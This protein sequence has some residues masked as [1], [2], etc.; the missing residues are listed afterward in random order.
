MK[1]NH[2]PINTNSASK[3][4]YDEVELYPNQP[5][6]FTISTVIT[7]SIDHPGDAT[8]QIH[9]TTGNLVFQYSETHTTSGKK[10]IR[11]VSSGLKPG[12]YTCTLLF[13]NGYSTVRLQRNMA[14][15][16]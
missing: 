6:P 7:Y 4:A 11:Y 5:N 3:D 14:Y 8:L 13:N 2:L 9:D 12:Q 15:V 10:K 16:K 1:T